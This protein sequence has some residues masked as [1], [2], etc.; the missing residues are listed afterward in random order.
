M[1]KVP[2]LPNNT[3]LQEARDNPFLDKGA[4]S[5]KSAT[6][7]KY[8]SGKA[9][10]SLLD[11]DWLLGVARVLDFGKKKYAAHN[12]RQ[13]IAISRLL[14]AALRHILAFNGG[15]DIDPE[16]GLPHLDH[17]SCCLMFAAGMM[18]T[19]P[20]LDDRYIDPKIKAKMARFLDEY[21]ATS[22]NRHGA[23]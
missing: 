11:G 3:T 22:P 17:A 9:P 6:G 12:W 19:R 16:S 13:G 18:R 2:P 8:D 7:L 15:E 10:L 21:D 14:D 1:D 4:N 23:T 5:P 20:D